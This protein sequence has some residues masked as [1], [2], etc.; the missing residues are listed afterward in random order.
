L[1]VTGFVAL[2][3]PIFFGFVIWYFKF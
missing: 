2:F 3:L 1:S